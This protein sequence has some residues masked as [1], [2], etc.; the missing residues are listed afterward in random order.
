MYTIAIDCGASFIKYAVFQND[1][2]IKLGS[3][4]SPSKIVNDDNILEPSRILDL[5]NKVKRLIEELSC[6]LNE[7]KIVI[8]NEMH[9][10]ILA[11]DNS[12]PYTDYI[13]WQTELISVDNVKA[14]LEK[15]IEQEKMW[16]CIRN[17][18]MP[19]RSGL[20]VS[21]MV[22]LSQNKLL[23]NKK[24]YFYTLG[25]YLLKAIFNIDPVCHPTNA[26][27]TG[28]YDLNSDNWNQDYI[29]YFN[30]QKADIVFPTVGKS[31][32]IKIINEVKYIIF[33]AIG[34]QQAAL[35]GCGFKDDSTL[36]FNMGTGAQVSR[37]TKNIVYGDYQVR[38]YFYGMYLFTIP[39]IPCG[40]AINVFFRFF[41]DIA[42]R[43]DKSITDEAIWHIINSELSSLSHY[44][45]DLSCDLSF[46]ENALTD[47]SVGSITNISE[48]N[49]L[50]ENIMKS[51]FFQIV[52]NFVSSSLRLNKNLSRYDNVLFTGGI[53]Q[54]M[55][56]LAEEIIDKLDVEK[57]KVNI[58]VNDTLYGCLM[59][60]NLKIE[61]R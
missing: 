58:S 28:L 43:I 3:F 4:S 24:L 2:I 41:K 33:P 40:R 7:V 21:A 23:D 52:D 25:D 42:V 47:H 44:S 26:A 9:G 61:D 54:R 36:S 30:D 6:G 5:V 11:D 15:K 29:C 55:P 38:P 57:N 50:F 32:Q 17:S 10:F 34:D 13:S 18:G 1:V 37:L 39:H 12:V 48:R 35:I 46:F 8:D 20:P 45:S 56:K 14:Y 60:S 19:L 22:W 27:A 53:A 59:F 51:V 49:F 31:E 16:A